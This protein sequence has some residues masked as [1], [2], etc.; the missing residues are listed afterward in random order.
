MF[1]VKEQYDSSRYLIMGNPGLLDNPFQTDC[2]HIMRCN[3]A[4]IAEETM[5]VSL[6]WVSM[7]NLSTSNIA[8]DFL[9]MALGPDAFT[10]RINSRRK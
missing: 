7:L 2:I 6:H 8:T 5:K 9:P 4:E 3:S 10:N 1:L